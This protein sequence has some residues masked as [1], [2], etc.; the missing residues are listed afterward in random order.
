MADENSNNTSSNT[1]K[2]NNRRNNKNNR[3][4]KNKSQTSTDNKTQEAKASDNKA[5]NSQQK[6]NKSRNR[7]PK[8]L[9][10]A[11]ILQKYDNLLDQHIV[12]RRKFFEVHGRL[13]GKQLEKVEHNFNKT[14]KA[15][16]EYRDSLQKDWQKEVLKEIAVLYPEDRQFTTTHE[17]EPIGESVPF[18]GEFEDPHLLPTQKATEW[19]SDTEESI[20]TMDD[21]K[22]Y[23]G[24]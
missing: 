21:Y 22:Q 19:A 24:N 10:P 1:K 13:T 3:Y 17:L 8:T 5:P 4:K 6:K 2:N 23:K 9:T 18:E 7:R 16:Y 11:R 14:L 15:L 20:G 12:A